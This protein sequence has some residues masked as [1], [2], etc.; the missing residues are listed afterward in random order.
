MR[1]RG[2]KKVWLSR[3]YVL[4]LLVFTT[5]G[6]LSA[7]SQGTAVPYVIPINSNIDQ[8]AADLVARGLEAARVSG[9]TAALIQLNTNGGLLGSTE[10][11]IDAIT[12]AE[13]ASLKVVVYVGPKGARAFSAGLPGRSAIGVPGCPCFVLSKPCVRPVRR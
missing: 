6:A 11:I 8:G 2:A 12:K 9:A 4:L 13:N 3:N 7:W 5:V 10:A 1:Q